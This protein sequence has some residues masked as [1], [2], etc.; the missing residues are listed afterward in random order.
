[1]ARYNRLLSSLAMNAASRNTETKIIRSNNFY[2]TGGTL[3]DGT[4]TFSGTTGFPGFSVAGFNS[5]EGLIS[6]DL[7]ENYIPIGTATDTIGNFVEGYKTATSVWIGD[8]PSANVGFTAAEYNTALGITTLDA[9]TTGDYNTA[10][11]YAAGGALTDSTANAF[12]GTYAGEV[13]NHADGHNTLIGYGAGRSRTGG[14]QAVSIGSSAHR[15]AGSSNSSVSIG[16][17]A[18]YYNTGS[19]NVHIGAQTAQGDSA[20]A[21]NSQVYIGK[22]AGYAS[23]AGDYTIGIGRNAYIY[24]T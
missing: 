6:G 13:F 11:G 14:T 3:T 24:W 23:I 8:D 7:S 17:Q 5:E 15:N 16:Y 1:M 22:T 4:V 20:S 9:I 21:G 10:V 2:V 18:G 12:F 19:N